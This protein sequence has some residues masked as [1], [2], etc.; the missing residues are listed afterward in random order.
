MGQLLIEIYNAY[1]YITQMG[2]YIFLSLKTVGVKINL[3]ILNTFE[4]KSA[5][6]MG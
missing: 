3:Y 5:S 4:V 2:G 1:T 6:V